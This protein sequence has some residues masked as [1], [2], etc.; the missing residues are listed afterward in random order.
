MVNELLGARID[1]AEADDG[2]ARGRVQ[3]D[4]ILVLGRHPLATAR[5]VLLEMAFVQAPQLHISPSRQAAQL[6]LLLR[7]SADRP[8]R[9]AGGACVTERPSAEII[10][11]ITK[12]ADPR[13]IGVLIACRALAG[14]K[15]WR[16][17]RSPATSC[18][19]RAGACA[20]V[21]HR[22]YGAYQISRPHAVRPSCL[23]QSGGG[24]AVPWRRLRRTTPPLADRTD[25]PPPATSMQS[26]IV[27]EL[28]APPDLLLVGDLHHLDIL[29]PQLAHRSFRRGKVDAMISRRC[30]IY[31]V[32]FK[33]GGRS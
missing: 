17:A 24:S 20:T 33:C 15:A 12:R 28:F 25:R 16:P 6:F 31:F 23:A 14:R 21:S 13:N 22:A 10:S 32:R 3:R 29:N 19:D 2:Y 4:G 7:L 11:G 27:A 26:M 9:L 5:P 1:R 8:E 30:I 18:A